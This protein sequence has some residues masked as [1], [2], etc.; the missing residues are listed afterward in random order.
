MS[1]LKVLLLKD[2]PDDTSL[3]FKLYAE[4]LQKNLSNCAKL[5]VSAH[6]VEDYSLSNHTLTNHTLTSRFKKVAKKYLLYPLT[7]PTNNYDIFHILTNFYG[8]LV[9]PLKL[10]N[11]RIVV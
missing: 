10:H 4:E 9:W 8:H 3:S 6:T 1:T 7:I 11:K 5:N 2:M